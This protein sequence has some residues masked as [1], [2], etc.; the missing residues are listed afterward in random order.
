MY[1]YN[2]IDP[3]DDDGEHIKIEPLY[4]TQGNLEMARAQLGSGP[5]RWQ[6]W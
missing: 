6:S 4:A 3:S 2:D 1:K 5:L